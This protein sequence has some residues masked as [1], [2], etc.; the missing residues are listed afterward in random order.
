MRKPAAV[1]RGPFPC[2]R[3]RTFS[4][5]P[6]PKEVAAMVK[7]TFLGTTR[8]ASPQDPRFRGPMRSAHG[9]GPRRGPCPGVLGPPRTR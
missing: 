8:A 7:T 4:P 2:L 6:S 1:G 3:S 9:L 5:V